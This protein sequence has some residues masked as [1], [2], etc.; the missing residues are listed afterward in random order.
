M[1][2][3]SLVIGRRQWA[4]GKNEATENSMSIAI[5]IAIACDKFI[6]AMNLT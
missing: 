6:L 3:M 5:A 4:G 1:I 2:F